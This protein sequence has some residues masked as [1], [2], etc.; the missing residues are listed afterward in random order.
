MCFKNKNEKGELIMI[1]VNEKV[2]G[3]K[4]V[5]FGIGDSVPPCSKRPG[6]MK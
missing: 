2:N 1:F 4:L 6:G 5:N 3:D